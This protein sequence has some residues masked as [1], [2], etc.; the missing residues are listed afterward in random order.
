MGI[1]SLSMGKSFT[2]NEILN[3]LKLLRKTALEP[4]RGSYLFWVNERGKFVPMRKALSW[5]RKA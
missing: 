4:V 2:D 3:A 5:L 1:V